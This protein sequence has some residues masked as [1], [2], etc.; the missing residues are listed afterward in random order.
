MARRLIQTVACELTSKT[1]KAY[2]DTEWE[3]FIVVPFSGGA[4]NWNASYHTEDR[5]DALTNA[6]ELAHTLDQLE[7][8]AQEVAA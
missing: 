1:I 6:I 7:A 2:R 5:K 3:E 4:P 8:Q